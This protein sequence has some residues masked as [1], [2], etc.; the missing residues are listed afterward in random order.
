MQLYQYCL[1]IVIAILVL[2]SLYNIVKTI[3]NVNKN[4]GPKVE[5]DDILNRNL[6]NLFISVGLLSVISLVYILLIFK[7]FMQ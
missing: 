7:Q 1:I 4:K 2:V 6:R 5:Q 3:I